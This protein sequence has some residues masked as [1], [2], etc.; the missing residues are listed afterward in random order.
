MGALIRSSG[1]SDGEQ[2]AQWRQPP[3]VEK[4][5]QGGPDSIRPTG[6]QGS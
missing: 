1:A 2:N 6:G 5:V 3:G 4:M